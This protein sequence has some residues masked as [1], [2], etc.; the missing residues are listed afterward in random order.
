MRSVPSSD[1]TG[2]ER[3]READRGAG[4][5]KKEK[6]GP[7]AGDPG[8]C[9]AALGDMR[10]PRSLS[11]SASIGPADAISPPVNKTSHID[12]SPLHACQRA[13]SPLDY[14][15]NFTRQGELEALEVGGGGS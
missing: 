12:P 14:G 8:R 11:A 7:L 1:P 5:P 3:S 13:P 6:P 10:V 15:L 2:A 4:A 9:T